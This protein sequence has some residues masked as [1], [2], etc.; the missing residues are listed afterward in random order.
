MKP[1]NVSKKGC[2][3]TSSTCVIWTGKDIP[4]INLCN[5]DTVSDVVYELACRLCGLL[6]A[7]DPANYDVTCLTSS[8]PPKT[9]TEL[10]ELIISTICTIKDSM[11]NNTQVDSGSGCPDCLIPAATCFQEHGTALQIT[12]YVGYLGTMVCNLKTDIL[13]LQ[14]A[15]IALQNRVTALEG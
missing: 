12:D 1:V 4:C 6:D 3:P 11:G 13:N 15:N 8:C 9:F 14:Q 7:T 2:T 5:G 10:L